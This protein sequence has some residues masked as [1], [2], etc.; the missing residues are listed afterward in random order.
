MEDELGIT[1]SADWAKSASYCLGRGVYRVLLGQLSSRTSR[2]A[3]GHRCNVVKPGNK[4]SP[5]A[6]FGRQKTLTI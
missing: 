1:I 2:L 3:V 4:F 6:T 5:N